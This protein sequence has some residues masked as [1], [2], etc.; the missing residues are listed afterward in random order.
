[1]RAL[2][3]DPV[4]VSAR[5]GPLDERVVGETLVHAGFEYPGVTAIVQ[6]RWGRMISG[7]ADQR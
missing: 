5:S 3:G 2:L 6:A 4:R 7:Y 1:M